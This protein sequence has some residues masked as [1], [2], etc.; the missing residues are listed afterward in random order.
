MVAVSNRHGLIQR[1]LAFLHP[2]RVVFPDDLRSVPKQRGHILNA[3]AAA[4]Q[5]GGESVAELV[6][7]RIAGELGCFELRSQVKIPIKIG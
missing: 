6:R 1:L 5:F 2:R 3:G 4:Q 7:M